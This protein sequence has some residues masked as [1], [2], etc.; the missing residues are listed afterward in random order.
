MNKETIELLIYATTFSIIVPTFIF[1]SSLKRKRVPIIQR[2]SLLSMFSLLIFSVIVL[3]IYGDSN[4]AKAYSKTLNF[5][6]DF[7]PIIT[8]PVILS[9]LLDD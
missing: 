3:D 5:I 9:Y 8:I 6:K 4:F 2:L 1:W 7:L